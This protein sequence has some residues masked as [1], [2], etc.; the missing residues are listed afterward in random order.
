MILADKNTINKILKL[1][2]LSIYNQSPSNTQSNKTKKQSN[3][4][5]ITSKMEQILRKVL[6][7][8]PGF[9]LGI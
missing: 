6:T 3:I 2:Q 5:I 7:D 1:K 4:I 9:S 8:K